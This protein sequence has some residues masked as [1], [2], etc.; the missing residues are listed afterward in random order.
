MIT[1]HAM[2]NV[3]GDKLYAYDFKGLSTDD[4]PTF[5]GGKVIE[6]NSMFL[7]E[8]TGDFYYVE[9]QGSSDTPA[10]WKKVGS[11]ASSQVQG[12]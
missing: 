7:E 1:L 5:W 11:G 8:D 4:K 6:A 3:D 10:V 12:E 9:S 2:R